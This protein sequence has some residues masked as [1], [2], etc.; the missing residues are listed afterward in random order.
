MN[1]QKKVA[2]LGAGSWGTALASL[3]ARNGHA[4]RLWARDEAA[5]Q[6][7]TS[8]GENVKYLPGVSLKNIGVSAVLSQ[9]LIDADWIVCAVPCAGV[10]NVAAQVAALAPANAILV[11]GTKG[12]H[13]ESGAR[14]AQIW[15][16]A[17]NFGPD[18]YVALSGPNLSREIIAGVPTSTVVASFNSQSATGAQELFASN[19]FR[20]Y[21]NADLVGVELGGALKNV[22]A[23]AAGICDGLGYGDNAKAAIMTRHWREMTRLAVSLGARQETLFGLSGIGD[24]F[25]TCASRHSRNHTVGFKL[26]RGETLSQAQH[27]IAQVAEGVH[28]TRA[29]LQLG[30]EVGQELPVTEQLAAILF[31]GRDVRRAIKELMSRS[32]GSE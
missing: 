30:R 10:P 8:A 4:V 13:P 9:V 22:V 5:A 21:T 15:E 17:G 27:E 25:A 19:L 7:L 2:V 29:A 20:V 12:L 32:G 26:G 6:G 18:R 16:K 14:G 23:I 3:A 1:E 28:T 31:E 11:S 24:L